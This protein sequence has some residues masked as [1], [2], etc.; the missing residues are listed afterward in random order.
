MSFD[1]S[2]SLGIKPTIRSTGCPSL[3]R[4]SVGMLI[5]PYWNAESLFVIYV[6]LGYL[7]LPFVLFGDFFQYRCDHLAWSAPHRPEIHH[8]GQLGV[9]HDLFKGLVSNFESVWP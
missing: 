3:N 2:F 6:Q 9:Q 4:I 8:R 7:E 1:R 5:T